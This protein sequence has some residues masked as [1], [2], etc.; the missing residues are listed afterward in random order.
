MKKNNFFLKFTFL[1]TGLLGLIRCISNQG[2]E[3]KKSAQ[4]GNNGADYFQI[5]DSIILYKG[6]EIVGADNA[7]FVV[8][9]E[10]YAKDAK[11]AYYCTE[12]RNSQ[13]YYTTKSRQITYLKSADPTSFQLVGDQYSGVAKDKNQGYIDGISFPITDYETFE[14]VDTKITK[15]RLHVYFKFNKVTGADASTFQN[16]DQNF[17]LDKQMAYF[18]D[19]TDL[20]AFHC[21]SASFLPLS[22]PFSKDDKQVFYKEKPIS[23]V[24]IV[25][26]EIL[27]NSYSKDSDHV[28]FENHLVQ[29]AS[30][31]DF[32]LV[33]GYE[34]T[35]TVVKYGRDKQFVYNETNK[36]V[37]RDPASFVILDL[38]YTKDASNVYF[39]NSKVQNANPETFEVFPHQ[40]GDGDA[41][42]KNYVFL[43]GRALSKN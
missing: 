40:V 14:I 5:T 34:N 38:G 3:G 23:G 18:L 26:F 31:K 20:K 39:N 8:L 6:E 12:S 17:Y 22:Y 19:G 24:K 33:P 43:K 4:S 32:S 13:D 28:Y 27:G 41:K 29:N 30:P 35:T 1:I 15:D 21:N 10:N 36:L 9:S 25:S 37:G 16:I 2:S 42:D 7:S 11:M